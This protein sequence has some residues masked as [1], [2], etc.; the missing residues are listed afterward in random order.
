MTRLHPADLV[1]GSTADEW[2]GAIGAAG[3]STGSDVSDLAAFAKL[4]PL[5]GI[6][7]TLQPAAGTQ[8]SD[9]ATEEYLR[10]VYAGYHFWLDGR[11]TYSVTRERLV[12]STTRLDQLSSPCLAAASYYQF[13]ERWFWAQPD[14]AAAHE[15]LDGLFV[16]PRGRRGKEWLILAVLGLREQREGFS[17]ISVLAAP[18]DMISTRAVARDPV[19]APVMAG[20]ESAGFRS[21]IS[22]AELL[23]LARLAMESTG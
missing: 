1:F 7:A 19:F 8:P 14:A 11:K 9:E 22:I 3:S 17:Q 18:D 21:V 2:F 15:P 16:I 12:A 23:L 5:P 20:G 6:L 10:L 13:P 4:P